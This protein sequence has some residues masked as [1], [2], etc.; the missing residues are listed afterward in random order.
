MANVNPPGLPLTVGEQFT[1]RT[2]PR[3]YTKAIFAIFKSVTIAT[4]VVLSA[5]VMSDFFI[6]SASL[7][8]GALR[9]SKLSSRSLRPAAIG[10]YN[11]RRVAAIDGCLCR[12]ELMC[13]F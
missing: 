12:K 8:C 4:S 11:L 10:R 1:I 5:F 6:V 9:W 3:C 13:L 7:G 2:G